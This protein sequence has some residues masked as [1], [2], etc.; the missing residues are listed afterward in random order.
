MVLIHFFVII[1]NQKM[2]CQGDNISHNIPYTVRLRIFTMPVFENES[3]QFQVV[4]EKYQIKQGH[5]IFLLSKMC[6]YVSNMEGT[7]WIRQRF[8]V[9]GDL[10]VPFQPERFAGLRG[11][12]EVVS[13]NCIFDASSD[14]TPM[15]LQPITGNCLV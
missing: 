4:Q 13:G 2:F 9:C 11:R 6:R 3:M 14:I 7:Q 8:E 5:L 12:S 1:L 10:R 15:Y